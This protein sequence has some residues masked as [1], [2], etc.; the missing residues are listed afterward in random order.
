MRVITERIEV[1]VQTLGYLFQTSKREVVK[2]IE[3]GEEKK[4]FVSES[5]HILD[6]N[7]F[8]QSAIE[9]AEEFR[10]VADLNPRVQRV[11]IHDKVSFA[12]GEMPSLDTQKAVISDIRASRDQGKNCPY[13]A[14]GHYDRIDNNE[15]Y[16]LHILSSTVRLDGSWVDDSFE[17]VKMKQ[18]E[19]EIELKRGLEYCPPKTAGTRENSSIREHK[20]RE[21]GKPIKKDELRFVLDELSQDQPSMPV[22]VARV[23]AAGYDANFCEFKDGKGLKFAD[24]EGN[25]FKGRDLGDRFSFRGLQ[26]YWGVDYQGDRDDAQLRE[27]NRMD[28]PQCQQF[29]NRVERDQHEQADLQLRPTMLFQEI[30]LVRRSPQSQ[31]TEPQHSQ[32]IEHDTST[33]ELLRQIE[34]SNQ[35]FAHLQSIQAERERKEAAR[36][37]QEKVDQKQEKSP[38]SRCSTQKQADVEWEL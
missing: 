19:R 20:L 9:L 27:L 18:V 26:K 32:A 16:H 23:K 15:V 1:P 22:L 28:R 34:L 10:Y 6:T 17:R 14:V 4:E 3:D 31:Q 11:A 24:P 7:M 38:H 13:V 8:G 25:W 12:P 5:Q 21:Q 2:F 29:L 36:K 30:E 33:D 35:Q 37:K